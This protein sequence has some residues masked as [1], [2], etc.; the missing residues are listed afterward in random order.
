MPNADGDLDQKFLLCLLIIGISVF[1]ALFIWPKLSPLIFHTG[2]IAVNISRDYVLDN[3]KE[4]VFLVPYSHWDPDWWM[5]WN[6][7]SERVYGI[8]PNRNGNGEDE[9]S[10]NDF[11]VVYPAVKKV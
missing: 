5:P 6:Q 8:I 3:A 9:C 4:V 1:L 10:Y 7:S 2:N 11:F